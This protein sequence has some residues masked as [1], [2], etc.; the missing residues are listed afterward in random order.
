MASFYWYF[1]Q[2]LLSL[3]LLFQSS[4]SFPAETNSANNAHINQLISSVIAHGL[5]PGSPPIDPE[6]FQSFSPRMSRTSQVNSV[7]ADHDFGTSLTGNA[8]TTG[9]ATIRRTTNQQSS[10]PFITTSAS[11]QLRS[12]LLSK[13]QTAPTSVA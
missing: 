10:G 12:S 11:S 2:L 1:T 5:G 8:I 9:P 6:L 7:A 4:L 3:S 13:Q